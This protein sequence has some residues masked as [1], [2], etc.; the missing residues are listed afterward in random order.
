MAILRAEEIAAASP[1]LGA[2][3]MGTSDLAKD[4]RAGHTRDRLPFLTS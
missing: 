3:V 1:R 4:L 2:F